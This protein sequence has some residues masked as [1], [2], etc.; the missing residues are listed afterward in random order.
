MLDRT[1]T[2]PITSNVV[3]YLRSYSSTQPVQKM[4]SCEFFH[5]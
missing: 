3:W 5:T 1:L 2:T 4:F